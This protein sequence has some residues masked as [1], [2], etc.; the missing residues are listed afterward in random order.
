MNKKLLISQVLFFTLFVN[1]CNTNR[2]AYSIQSK[3]DKVEVIKFMGTKTTQPFSIDEKL[4]WRNEDEHAKLLIKNIGFINDIRSIEDTTSTYFE[5]YNY[6]F[7]VKSGRQID[8][9]YSDSTLK[10]W[11]LKK[12]DKNI[13]FYDRNGE[14]AENLRQMFSF[15]KDCW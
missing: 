10:S 13:Y 9:L 11:I 1:S 14:I 12:G 6:A 4:F 15:F 5:E 7:L 2:N 3:V 8:T